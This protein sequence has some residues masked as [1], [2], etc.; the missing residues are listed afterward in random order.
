M[1]DH[2]QSLQAW[3][4]S[5]MGQY[6]SDW[7]CSEYDRIVGNIFGYHALQL[8]LPEIDGLRA[9]RM[10][11]RWHVQAPARLGD[12]TPA[13]PDLVADFAS[14]PFA[15]ASLDL[16]VMPHSLELSPDAHASLRE[17]ERVLLPEGRVVITGF[18][19]TGL[20]AMRQRRAHIT[21]RWGWGRRVSPELSAWIGLRRLRDW[22]KLLGLELEQCQ[23]GC[24]RPAF[25]TQTWL[26]RWSWMDKLGPRWW[27]VLG[28]VYCVVAVKRVRGMRLLGPAWKVSRQVARAPAQVTQQIHSGKLP[29]KTGRQ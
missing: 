27:P 29:L 8:G 15:S 12:S 6:V 17:V 19:P 20:W 26:D 28:S 10:S 16:V 3:L 14:L 24:Y 22:L 18:N 5:P 7:E 9:N 11:C 2:I 13:Q 21:R 25:G 23:L 4:S 1:V